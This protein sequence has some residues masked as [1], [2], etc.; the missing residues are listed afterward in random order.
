MEQFISTYGYVAI[1]LGTFI[2]GETVLIAGGFLAHRGYLELPWVIAAA[3]MG[4]LAADQ[5]YFFLGRKKGLPYLRKRP[6]WQR[7]AERVFDLLSKYQFWIILGFRFL[8]GFRIV[9]PFLIGASG[10]APV[11]F[12]ALNVIG[13]AVWAVIFG[14]LGYLLGPAFELFLKEAKRY[15]LIVVLAI[16]MIGLVFWVAH[17]HRERKNRAKRADPADSSTVR[18]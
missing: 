12:V 16:I 4:T 1:L 9:T 17:F 11:R 2:E 8:Y 6:T 10:F 3:F 18:G 7:K 14:I 13:A 15:E 5:L